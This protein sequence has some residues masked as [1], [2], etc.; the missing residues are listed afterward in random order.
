MDLKGDTGEMTIDPSGIVM[1]NSLGNETIIID[2][3]NGKV[4]VG[5]TAPGAKLDVKGIVY[6]NEADD[7]REYGL[8]L[9][10]SGMTGQLANSLTLNSRP[11]NSWEG[12]DF[13]INGSSKMFLEMVGFLGIGTTNPTA[14]I[15]IM[16]TS[17]TATQRQKWHVYLWDN[18][19]GSDIKRIH[20]GG[21]AS[22]YWTSGSIS[23]H[24]IG[25]IYAEIG[26][27]VSSD[28][29]IKTDISSV[30]DDRA[31]NQVNQLQCKEYHYIDPERRR[32]LKTIGFI[33]QD[34]EEVLP[35]AVTFQNEF[36]PDEMRDIT[37][38]QWNNH[39]LTIPDLDMSAD[40]LTGKCK[41]YVSDDEQG[42]TTCKEIDCDRDSDGNKTNTFSFDK[43][44]ERI[45]F[46]GRQVNDFQV[47]DKNQIFAL[48]HS[49]IQELSRKNDRLEAENAE[50]K[51]RMDAM[52]AAIIALQNN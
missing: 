21:G 50:L 30:D 18:G 23:L 8:Q 6:I 26:F 33:S 51:T 25:R 3:S 46:Y 11:N 40:N 12:I 34:V 9:Q 17:G 19:Y 47:L 32:P 31:L 20:A 29:R 42:E 41:F 52:E 49:A 44:Y 5:T 45:L 22:S 15:D 1:K 35:N 28:L 7:A 2:G 38:P 43:K 27:V 36:I 4:G 16:N 10:R 14:P 37:E 48:H 24:T 39:K 13:Q